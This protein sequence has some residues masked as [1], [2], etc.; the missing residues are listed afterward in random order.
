MGCSHSIPDDHPHMFKARNLNDQD[1]SVNS[2]II[3]GEHVL[4]SQHLS[5]LSGNDVVCQVVVA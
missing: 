1:K 4:N 2:V 5:Y 3:E